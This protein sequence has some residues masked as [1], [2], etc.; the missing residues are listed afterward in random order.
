MQ[1]PSEKLLSDK[2][3]LVKLS[4]HSSTQ[5][6]SRTAAVTAK[7]ATAPAQGSKPVVVALTA[8]AQAANK[9]ISIVEIAKRELVAKGV[10][11]YQYNALGSEMTEIPRDGVKGSEGV[12]EDEASEGEE[13]AFETMRQ[14]DV[15]DT[16]KRLIPVMTTYLS[17]TAIKEL[18]TAHG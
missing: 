17:S 1:P 5:I 10:A 8:K 2:Y 15:G 12:E 9:V 13:A 18:R 16:K 14:R 4:V 11:V 6:S 3:E 7:L